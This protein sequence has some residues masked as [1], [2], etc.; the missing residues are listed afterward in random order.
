MLY[1]TNPH[2]FNSKDPVCVLSFRRNFHD[3]CDTNDV[4][5]EAAMWLMTHVLDGA[6]K[7]TP[8]RVMKS[9]TVSF[10]NRDQTA[11]RSY[12]EGVN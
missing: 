9:L 4:H 6:P 1:M 2:W 7:D 8:E 10:K 5:E 11:V 3:A 12:F